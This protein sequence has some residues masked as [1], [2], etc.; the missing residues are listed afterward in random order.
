MKASGDDDHHHFRTPGHACPGSDDR[1]DETR[2]ARR[3]PARL[4]RLSRTDGGGYAAHQQPAGPVR[5][6]LPRRPRRRHGQRK[7]RL[8]AAAA[9]V[10]AARGPD[11]ARSPPL[12]DVGGG[13]G[14]PGHVAGEPGALGQRHRA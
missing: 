10:R 6:P 3:A 13:H 5:H 1:A 9:G 11:A 12:R 8:V 4:S 7:I 14:L 2:R